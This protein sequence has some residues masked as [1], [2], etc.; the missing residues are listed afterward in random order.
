MSRHGAFL[1]STTYCNSCSSRLCSF[2]NL[3]RSTAQYCLYFYRRSRSSFEFVGLHAKR[4]KAHC[5]PRNYI[6][7]ALRD[8]FQL[9][10]QPSILASRPAR[11][12]HQYHSC[13]KPRVWHVEYLKIYAY[14]NHSSLGE[15]IRNGV[16]WVRITIIFP[17][18][19]K[20]LDTGLSV[21]IPPSI[22]GSLD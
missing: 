15:T 14:T 3:Q 17:S 13:A 22:A 21:W 19:Y 18:G 11:P 10:S 1:S 5:G 20:M 7:Q 2:T 9:L 4:A 8:R 12:Q 6:C 16:W